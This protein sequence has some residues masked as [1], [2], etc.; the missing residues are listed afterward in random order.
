M[1]GNC[2]TAHLNNAL[3]KRFLKSTKENLNS[4]VKLFNELKYFSKVPCQITAYECFLS[5]L[6]NSEQLILKQSDLTWLSKVLGN[7]PILFQ[8]HTTI[9][10]LF[11][12]APKEFNML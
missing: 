8:R 6:E 12:L 10:F 3:G 11:I 4:K 7:L 1:V 9:S 5:S 2:G